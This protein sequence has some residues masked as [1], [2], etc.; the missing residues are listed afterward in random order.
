MAVTSYI[1]SFFLP[2]FI[3]VSATNKGQA[4]GI[5]PLWCNLKILYIIYIIYDVIMSFISTQFGIVFITNI[6][7]SMH[8]RARVSN[9]PFDLKLNKTHQ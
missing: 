2:F 9:F 1:A 8:A 6:D 3:F 4:D 7:Y 5:N